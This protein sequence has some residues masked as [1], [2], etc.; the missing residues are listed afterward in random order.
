MPRTTPNVEPSATSNSALQNISPASAGSDSTAAQ[1]LPKRASNGSISVVKLERAHAPRE[2][3]AAENQADAEAEPALQS[4]SWIELVG[5][6]GSAEQIAAVHPRRRHRERRQPQ[7][8]RPA[9]NHE[10]QASA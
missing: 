10:F 1:R 2:E 4:R 5:A 3:H 8:H 6:F 9:R 7:R